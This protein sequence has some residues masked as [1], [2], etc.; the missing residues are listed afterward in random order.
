MLDITKIFTESKIDVKS[1]NIRTSKKGTAT[2]DIGFIVH[3]RE[4]LNR[5]IEKLHHL[6]GILDIERTAG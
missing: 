2:L 3:G 6:E 1:L 5:M 4:E